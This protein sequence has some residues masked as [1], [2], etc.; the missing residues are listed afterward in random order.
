MGNP[1]S[2]FLKGFPFLSC[3]LI[4]ED[5][6]T[7]CTELYSGVEEL[8]KDYEGREH[9]VIDNKIFVN[10]TDNTDPEIDILKK[11]IKYLTFQHPCWGEEMPNASVPLELEMA[12]LVAKSK[13]VL[14]LL[15]VEELNAIIKVSVL[16]NEELRDFIH[17]QPSFGTIVYFDTPQLRGYVIISPLLLV[18]VMR[19]FVT[20][21]ICY[22]TYIHCYTP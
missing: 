10:A 7:R 6:E 2:S 3:W 17:F 18:E 12:N 4:R 11:A 9:L 19:S 13:Q 21:T 14:S 16:S 20:G 5:I 8:F 15:E 22:N 1:Q